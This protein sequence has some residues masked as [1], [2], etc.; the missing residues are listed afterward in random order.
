MPLHCRV[1]ALLYLTEALVVL[2]EA[3]LI[4]CVY[5]GSL[6]LTVQ[7]ALTD[8]EL[9]NLA[10]KVRDGLKLGVSEASWNQGTIHLVIE[11]ADSHV[12]VHLILYQQIVAVIPRVLSHL[13]MAEL[14]LIY[15]QG[16][17]I[18]MSRNRTLQHVRVLGCDILLVVLDGE[19][20]L[21]L[22]VRLVLRLV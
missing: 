11:I 1:H 20:R 9:I 7:L 16:Q 10:I 12:W 2:L 4:P 3:P 14:D 19:P 18:V 17:I 8:G 21:L 6:L 13:L 15:R 22:H 5:V